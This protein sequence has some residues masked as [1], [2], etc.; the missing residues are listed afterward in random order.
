MHNNRRG[1]S[2]SNTK[3]FNTNNNNNNNNNHNNNNNKTISPERVAEV[4]D[5]L[6][7]EC[8]TRGSGDNMSV[9]VI[10]LDTPP[11]PPLHP[12]LGLAEEDEQENEG[13]KEEEDAEEEE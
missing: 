9:I 11:L 10:V 2:G 1:V 13:E 7:A 12:V 8:L 6:L 3:T 4:C 5:H